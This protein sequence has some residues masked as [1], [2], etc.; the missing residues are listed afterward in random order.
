MEMQIIEQYEDV[1][2]GNSYQKL[3][4]AIKT[5]QKATCSFELSIKFSLDSD[6][7]TISLSPTGEFLAAGTVDGKLA[8]WDMTKRSETPLFI[9]TVDT[10][11]IVSIQFITNTKLV[12]GGTSSDVHII[13]LQKEKMTQRTIRKQHTR[14]IHASSKVDD[15]AFLTC[16][17][18]KTVRIFDD[19]LEYNNSVTIPHKYEKTPFIRVSPYG[20]LRPLKYGGGPDCFFRGSSDESLL[21]DVSS[22][23]NGECYSLSALPG[24]PYSY[25]VGT[26][27]TEARVF[28]LRAPNHKYE[29]L[30]GLSPIFN[31]QFHYP[32]IGVTTDDYGEVIALSIRSGRVH[33]YNAMDLDVIPITTNEEGE[34][35]RGPNLN[36]DPNDFLNPNDGSLNYNDINSYVARNQTVF[37]MQIREFENIRRPVMEYSLHSNTKSLFNSAKFFGKCIIAGSDTGSIIVYDPDS[38]DI[39]SILHPCDDPITCICNTPQT[40]G[41]AACSTN[42]IYYYEICRPCEVDLEQQKSYINDLI[43]I[44][45]SMR[46]GTLFEVLQRILAFNQ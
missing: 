19:R 21:L 9:T 41:F 13:D 10:A 4:D 30:M 26:G 46:S 23:K 31:Y 16:S 12:V 8:M 38:T 7:Q 44:E 14:A 15:N 43:Q 45:T 20:K 40:L 42:N 25:A 37:L 11:E 22:Y 5:S 33:A 3:F 18:D 39:I 35:R 2:R 29:E 36:I 32:T 1:R 34:T 24:M 17:F 28:D 27:M 6:I